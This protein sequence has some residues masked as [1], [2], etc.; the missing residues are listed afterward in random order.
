MNSAT[1]AMAIIAIILLVVASVQQ[2]SFHTKGLKGGAKLFLDILPLMFLA[3]LIAG[4]MQELLPREFVINWLGEESGFKG[5][6]IGWLAGALAPDGPF[7]SYPIAR[8]LL[9]AGAGLSTVVTYM[10]AWSLLEL[11]RLPLEVSIMGP[12]FTAFRFAIIF[13][14][15]PI[16]G[17]TTRAVLMVRP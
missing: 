5:I 6:A 13:L 10:A 3:F 2:G 15:P 16:I 8:A 7:V 17:L 11:T 14:F 12:R 9:S 1:I 4:L